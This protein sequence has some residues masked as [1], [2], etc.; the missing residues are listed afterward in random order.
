[1]AGM[2][3]ITNQMASHIALD[4]FAML[5]GMTTTSMGFSASTF[6]SEQIKGRNV[7]KA[8]MVTLVTYIYSFVLHLITGVAAY[9]L[10]DNIFGFYST[11]NDV[12]I[13][14]DTV[15]TIWLIQHIFNSIL[16]VSFGVLRALN[17]A[18]LGAAG[19]ITCSY[20]ISLP[21][22]YFLG[23]EKEQMIRGLWMAPLVMKFI[24]IV[25]FFVLM[26]YDNWEKVAQQEGVEL[27]AVDFDEDQTE[28]KPRKTVIMFETPV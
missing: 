10:V 18:V 27:E 21:L 4:N 25:Y 11:S 24:L 9:F 19:I 16:S 28:K 15:F 7:V 26:G 5:I 8:K 1:M 20:V 14:F 13:I 17:K 3:C 23:F 2:F 12:R 6:V 22:C